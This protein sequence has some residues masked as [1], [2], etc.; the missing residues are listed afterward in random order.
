MPVLSK[1]DS[2]INNDEDDG[3]INSDSYQGRRRDHGSIMED[4][5]EDDDEEEE[6]VNIK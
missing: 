4:E 2:T 3:S 5:D 1:H 6:E